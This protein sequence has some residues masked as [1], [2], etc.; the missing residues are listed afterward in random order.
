MRDDIKSLHFETE[1]DIPHIPD[2][3]QASRD[4]GV[5]PEHV[6]NGMQHGEAAQ[7]VIQAIRVA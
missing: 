4:D 2:E 1:N 6:T 3:P 5:S 7:G